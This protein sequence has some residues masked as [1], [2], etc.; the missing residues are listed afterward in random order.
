MVADGKDWLINKITELVEPVVADMQLELVEVQF[1]REPSG[2]VL[3]LII[4]SADGIGIDQCVAVS[5][6]VGYLL[7]VEDVIDLAYHLEVSSPGL[8][9]PLTTERDF[10]RYLGKK[11]NVMAKQD[12]KPVDMT[13]IIAGCEE[14]T[15]ELQVEET[16]KHIPL[17]NIIKA[18]Q[19]IEF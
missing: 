13:G 3:R 8:D 14:G 12:D 16:I 10:K 6:E 1:R 9:R 2:Q 18:V 15:L 17:A 11:I 4:D 7:E 19:V 5:R